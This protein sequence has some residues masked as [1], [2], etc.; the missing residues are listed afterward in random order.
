MLPHEPNSLAAPLD[1][2]TLSD[3]LVIDTPEQMPLEFAI[4]GIG[5]RFL[6]LALDSVIQFGAGAGVFIVL[7]ILGATLP[8]SSLPRLWFLAAFG[9]IVFLLLFGYFAFFEIAWNGQTPGKRVVGLRVVKETGRPL[10]PSE[11]IGRN[12]MRIV[13]Q[14][15]A[16]YA[17]GMLV[18]LLNSK[19]KRL[20]DFIAGSVVVRETAM[21][22]IKPI[23]HTSQSAH[24]P[25]GLPL[26]EA[27]R[28]STTA[29]SLEELALV[30]A[31]LQ[32]RSDLAEDVRSRMAAE[33]VAR[34]Q[35]K[36]APGVQSRFSP[37]SLLEA[38]SYERRSSGSYS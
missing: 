36:L 33:I 9:F 24:P 6:A 2:L 26:S 31:F 11:A 19:N 27:A 5:S 25:G 1:K 8:L 18:A 23:W 14:L 30:D 16:F 35:P 21:K 15:P 13:D 20:G 34:L 38:L 12:L 32:R 29:L 37:E 17:V 4:A 3:K 28:I 22:D 10:T 7:A